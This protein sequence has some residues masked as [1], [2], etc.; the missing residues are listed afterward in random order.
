M[1]WQKDKLSKI[2]NN[3]SNVGAS[4][5]FLNQLRIQ[6][7]TVFSFPFNFVNEISQVAPTPCES[8]DLDIYPNTKLHDLEYSHNVVHSSKNSD[9]LQTLISDLRSSIAIFEMF[10]SFNLQSNTRSPALLPQDKC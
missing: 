5:V 9:R 7:C 1:H 10:C 3:Q 4:S 2:D 8:R 6:R